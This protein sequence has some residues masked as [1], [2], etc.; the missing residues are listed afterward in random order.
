MTSS[1]ESSL[2][3]NMDTEELEELEAEQERE[4]NNAHGFVYAAD[5]DT[6][7]LSKRERKD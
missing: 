1:E 3:S 7:R 4:Y 5:L 2:D 6:Y